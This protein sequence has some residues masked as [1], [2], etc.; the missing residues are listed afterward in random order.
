MMLYYPQLSTGAIA[1]YPL[2]RALYRRTVM[3]ETVSGAFLK[4]A[5]LDANA[6][7]WTLKYTGLTDA[8]R[9]AL[10]DLF[11]AVEGRLRH[12]VLLDPGSNL[13]RWSKDLSRPVWHSNPLLVVEQCDGPYAGTR[14]VR[15]TNGAQITQGIQQTLEA[16]AWYRYCFSVYARASEPSI[17]GVVIQST[18][19][20]VR[21]D[22]RVRHQWTR[23]TSSSNMQSSAEEVTCRI[24]IESGAS[25]EL[26]APQCEA[27]PN[28]SP[29][30]LTGENGGVHPNTRFADD[31]LRFVANGVDDH[32]ATVRLFSRM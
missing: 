6:I 25:I 10:E 30:I 14:A 8:E 24:E 31:T 3:N 15:V 1:Q 16:P 32:A 23:C 21:Q 18:N 7:S 20:T 19:E 28:P 9:A 27:Q 13:L 12:F 29:Y 2:Q 5:D 22:M 11:R 4:Y 26:F 17:V